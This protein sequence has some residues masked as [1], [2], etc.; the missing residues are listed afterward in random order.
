MRLSIGQA[1]MRDDSVSCVL[2]DEGSIDLDQLRID[3]ARVQS[4]VPAGISRVMLHSECSGVFLVRLLA[5]L[6]LGVEVVLPANG[7]PDTLAKLAAEHQLQ[8]DDDWQPNAGQPEPLRW[9]QQGRR[10]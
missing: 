10:T 2:T 9:S 5:L 8:M 6:G 1:L 3:I 4:S 7:Q